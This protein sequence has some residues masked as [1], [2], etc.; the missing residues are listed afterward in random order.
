MTPDELAAIVDGITPVI[1]DV[2]RTALA[3]VATRVQ[4]VE[5][6]MAGVTP[7]VTAI[8]ALRERVAVLETRPALPGPPGADGAPGPAG[9][10]GADG[11]P[12]LI[13]RGVFVDGQIYE[14]GHVVTYAGSSWHCNDTTTTKPGDGSRAWVLLVK[15]GRDGKDGAPGPVGPAG[16]DWQQVY[17]DTRGGR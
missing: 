14:R 17:D 2:V 8:G 12:G 13:F 3:D 4:T 1:R 7:A 10:D 5:T 11:T 16:R 6:Q 9:K 15:R